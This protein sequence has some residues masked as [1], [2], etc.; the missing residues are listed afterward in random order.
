VQVE[1]DESVR[2]RSPS[3]T[4]RNSPRRL[5]RDRRFESVIADGMKYVAE[6][7]RRF[8]V[9]IVDSTDPQGP[10]AVLFTRE[11]YAAC[12]RCMAP[13]AVMVTQ[14]GVPF[15]QAGRVDFI[16][17]DVQVAV[18]RCRLLRGGDPHLRGRPHGDGLGREGQQAAPA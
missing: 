6:T 16:G 15:L 8:D 12:K 5:F 1:I 10:G 9:I 18:R 11:F 4:S 7:E 3:S 2:S 17:R 14:N 13:G